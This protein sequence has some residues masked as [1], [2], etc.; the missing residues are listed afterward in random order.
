MIKPW[1]SRQS[2]G[3]LRLVL[4]HCTQP[5][6]CIALA[7]AGFLIGSSRGAAPRGYFLVRSRSGTGY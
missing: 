2:T 1:F 5:P 4:G 6:T 3:R 7:A